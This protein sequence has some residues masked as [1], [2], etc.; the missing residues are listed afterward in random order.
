MLC[1]IHFKEGPTKFTHYRLW[2]Y[3]N[4]QTFFCFTKELLDK[5]IA[6]KAEN[7]AIVHLQQKYRKVVTERPWFHCFILFLTPGKHV[8]QNKSFA[9][10]AKAGS[11]SRGILLA[12]AIRFLQSI[13]RPVSAP[14]PSRSN[15]FTD[16]VAL[17]QVEESTN[18]FPI[19]QVPFNSFFSSYFP[20][21]PRIHEYWNAFGKGVA[22]FQ[23][24]AFE[25]PPQRE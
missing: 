15:T 14:L 22:G 23:W 1:K 2:N 6:L 24:S 11:S 17:T 8:H 20:L 5:Q 25:K 3:F 13:T 9:V 21:Q 4:G 10:C 7:K 19:M 16:L 12:F 18:G